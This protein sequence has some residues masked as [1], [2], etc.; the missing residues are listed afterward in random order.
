MPEHAVKLLQH[1]GSFHV[2]FIIY[3][4]DVSASFKFDS[5]QSQPTFCSIVYLFYRKSR[6]CKSDAKNQHTIYYKSDANIP[7]AII[8]TGF[9]SFIRFIFRLGCVYVC[10]SVF[11][12]FKYSNAD[13]NAN[14]IH[15]TE[16]R[17]LCT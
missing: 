4:A 12:I 9:V 15:R 1:F 5:T 11:L 2:E 14:F 17:H 7:T 10:V 6:T 16:C 13:N 8:D 3:F